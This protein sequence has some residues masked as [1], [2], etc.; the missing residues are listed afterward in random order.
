MSTNNNNNSA[1][2]SI[3]VKPVQPRYINLN[4][5][6]FTALDVYETRVYLALR[7][8]A[9]YRTQSSDVELT[10]DQLIKI[11]KV[12]RS[13]LFEALNRLENKHFL[14]RRINWDK[15]TWGKAN[16]YEVAQHLNYF[17]PVEEEEKEEKNTDDNNINGSINGSYI[18]GVQE[19]DYIVQEVDD[20][21]QEV[22][23]IVHPVHTV[24]KAEYKETYYQQNEQKKSV[25]NMNQLIQ[26]NPH[27]LPPQMIEDW[28]C[29][30]KAKKAPVTQTA[31][32]RLNKELSKCKNPIEAF[33]ECVSAGWLSFK[34]EWIDK[35]KSK[36]SYFDH[37][38]MGWAKDL[39][40]DMF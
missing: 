14:I 20:I 35:Q 27:S 39:D 28:L 12:K 34:H 26:N 33:E 24:K 22:D 7:Y 29:N 40:K 31:W 3:K 1:T 37:D 10:V 5:N 15:K 36:E 23:D 6:I 13:T 38:T 18:E 8:Q 17:K 11:S 32:A 25:L 2:R 4:E 19:V 9:D 30:R 16:E 21:V